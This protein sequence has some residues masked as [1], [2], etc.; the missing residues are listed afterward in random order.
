VNEDREER[1]FGLVD[2]ADEAWRPA[3]E[4]ASLMIEPVFWGVGMQRGDGRP[5]LV[6]PGLYGGDRYLTPLRDWVRRIGYR[7]VPSGMDRNP[8]W[9]EQ[10]IDRL[11]ELTEREY[12][13]G[14]QRVTIIGHSMGGLQGRAVAARRAG[15][16]RHVIALGSPLAI[17]RGHLPD[18]VRMTALYS[19]G[20]RIV[21]HPA[22]LAR[23]PRAANVEVSGSHIGLTF[24]PGVYRALARILP[25]PDREVI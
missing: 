8:G 23:D 3:A 9:S 13:Q 10:I 6:L 21:R 25:S 12:R 24:N 22:A 16:V 20:D 15:A 5:V 18:E 2:L 11:V 4:L 14:G 17:A 19:R 1:D 7:A